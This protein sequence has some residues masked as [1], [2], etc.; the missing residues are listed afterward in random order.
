MKNTTN[1]MK[2]MRT[3]LILTTLGVL[4]AATAQAG[5]CTVNGGTTYQTIDGIGFSS[6]WCGTLTSA[7]NSALYS[8]LGMSLLRV[9]IDPN[10][11][12]SAE[13]ANAS[14]AHSAGAKVL[15]TPW[16]P[17]ASMKSNNNVNNGGALLSSQY[18]AYATYLNNA[19]SSI[20]LDYISLANEPDYSVTYESSSWTPAQMQTFCANNAGSLSKTVVMPESYHFSDTMSDPTLNSTTSAANVDIIAGHLYGGGNTVHQNALNKGKRVW[21]TEHYIS[22][23]DMANSC[24]I[25]KEITDCMNNRMS[26]YFWWWVYES[27]SNVNLVNTSGSIFKKGYAMGQFAKWVRPG[28]QRIAATYNPSTGVYVTAYRNNGLVIVAVNTS[29]STVWQ[30]FSIQNISGVSSMIV[31]RTTSSLNMSLIGNATVSS[32]SFGLSLPPQSVTTAHQY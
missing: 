14:A 25:A 2:P 5:T 3:A 19:S 17:P 32:G 11:S 10:Q 13:T 29:S 16:S 7:K 30:T 21:E 9:R 20:G 1:S 15:G 8:T 12:W 6:A 26:A 4:T 27:D 31:H 23:S 22:G 28:K 18:G 24:T